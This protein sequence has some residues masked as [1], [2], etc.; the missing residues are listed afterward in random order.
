MGEEKCRFGNVF[1]LC[2]YPLFMK[3][4]LGG[5]LG[6]IIVLFL[7]Q[8]SFALNDSNI[9]I[10]SGSVNFSEINYTQPENILSHTE[11]VVWIAIIVLIVILFIALFVLA[12]LLSNLN[13][14]RIVSRN[15][16]GAEEAITKKSIE[17][18]KR[19]S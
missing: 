7:I 8:F 2:Y 11:R 5:V 18:A 16:S 6:L 1:K 19:L 15:L 13:P 12:Y 4:I 17:R 9:S 14:N 3:R 10:P